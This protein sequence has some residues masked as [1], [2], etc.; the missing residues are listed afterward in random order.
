M[1]KLPSGIQQHFQDVSHSVHVTQS[2]TL[3]NFV[4]NLW[5]V[6]LSDKNRIYLLISMPHCKRP[7]DGLMYCK[8][9]NTPESNQRTT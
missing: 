1:S 7:Q 9:D 4:E 3:M 5:N 6:S 8:N 2:P